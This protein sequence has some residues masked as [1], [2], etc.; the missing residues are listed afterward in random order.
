MDRKE[1]EGGK[2]V[3]GDLDIANFEKHCLCILAYLWLLLTRIYKQK[4]LAKVKYLL[5]PVIWIHQYH[6]VLAV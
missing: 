5:D 2:E 4:T 6:K 1:K 3:G